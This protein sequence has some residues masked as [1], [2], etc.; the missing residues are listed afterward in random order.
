VNSPEFEFASEFATANLHCIAHRSPLLPPPL[1]LFLLVLLLLLHVRQHDA[2]RP[3]DDSC[4]GRHSVCL[5]VAT[6]M[7]DIVITFVVSGY[8]PC[9]FGLFS[10]AC[11]VCLCPNA[12]PQPEESAS[13]NKELEKLDQ[14]IQMLVHTNPGST[15]PPLCPLLFLGASN[16]QPAC[17]RH[18]PISCSHAKPLRATI[19]NADEFLKAS[20]A[21]ASRKAF[22]ALVL[23]S[24][25]V[26]V[27]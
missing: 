9:L 14:A 6:S 13:Q 10:R 15:A 19:A 12:Y 23:V 2:C 8:S 17:C 7:S 3:L 22:T 4:C 16:C 18:G 21:E 26:R 11:S 1:L 27:G 20:S 24:V 25:Y 5:E